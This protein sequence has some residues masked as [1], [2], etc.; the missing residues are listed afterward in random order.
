MIGVGI[1]C[2]IVYFTLI[3]GRNRDFD[4]WFPGPRVLTELSEK[5]DENDSTTVCWLNCMQ[6]FPS[7]LELLWEE[8]SVNFSKSEVREQP[9]TYYVNLSTE[10]KG[11]FEFCFVLDSYV[12][13]ITN[14]RSSQNTKDCECPE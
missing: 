4:F 11:E 14:I 6:V 12:A 13:R 2:L 8:A 3:R 7:D 10:D 5:F 9:Q 1:G